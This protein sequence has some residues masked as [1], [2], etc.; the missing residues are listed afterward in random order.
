MKDSQRFIMKINLSKNTFARESTADCIDRFIGGRGV[1]SK[2]LFEELPA[3]ADPL[4]PQNVLVLN[5]GPLSGSAAPASGRTDVSALSPTNNYHGGTNFGG[6][7]GAAPAVLGAPCSA[8]TWSGFR[9][10][11]TD[12]PTA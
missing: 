9:K 8:C 4:G 1:G 2:I 11:I 7:W 5:T 10:V 6:F 3:G 12:F